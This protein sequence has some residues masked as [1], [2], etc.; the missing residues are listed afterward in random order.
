MQPAKLTYLP[1]APGDATREDLGV[2]AE[3]GAHMRGVAPAHEEPG[4]MGQRGERD[5]GADYGELGPRSMQVVEL[6][7]AVKVP[8]G[9]AG[10]NLRRTLATQVNDLGP[11]VEYRQPSALAEA[12][13][14]VHVLE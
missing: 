10:R 11:G 5:R 14:E 8:D 3:Q 4:E 7:Q 2:G 13:A 1:D 9:T 12:I 6:Q